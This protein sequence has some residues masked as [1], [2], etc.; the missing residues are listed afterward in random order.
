[1]V[2]AWTSCR[3]VGIDADVIGGEVTAPGS[4]AALAGAE[5]D[6]DVD[7]RACE[8]GTDGI[9]VHWHRLTD[10]E[11][12]DAADCNVAAVER[13]AGATAS[14]S[15]DDPSPVGV[16]SV[17]GALDERAEDHRTCRTAGL[18][19]VLC[20]ID[21]NADRLGATFGIGSELFHQRQAD[22]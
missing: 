19:E 12:L 17:H 16:G 18:V 5:L 15:G 10:G 14:Q 13:E 9:E 2:T 3:V 21:R 11:H 4:R 22:S 6:L 8:G 20:A 7:A 1:M